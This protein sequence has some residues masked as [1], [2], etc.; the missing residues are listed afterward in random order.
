MRI[1]HIEATDMGSDQQDIA[2]K[3]MDMVDG[4]NFSSKDEFAKIEGQ[5]VTQACQQLGWPSVPQTGGLLVEW[6]FD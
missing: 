3:V 5:L 6:E 1:F 2:D 4:R